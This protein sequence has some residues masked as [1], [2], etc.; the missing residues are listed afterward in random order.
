[1]TTRIVAEGTRF[2][3]QIDWIMAVLVLGAA[4]ASFLYPVLYLKM[5]F[6]LDFNS[7]DFNPAVLV[8][9]FLGVFGLKYLFAAVL[10]T[11][12]GRRFGQAV[13]E[14]DGETVAQGETLKGAVRVPADLVPL[15]DYE[16]HLQC[17]HQQYTANGRLRDEIRWEETLRVNA[18]SANRGGGV[19]FAFMI[20]RD[21]M[22]TAQSTL[23]TGQSVRWI[24]EVKAPLKGLNFYAIFG[25]VVRARPSV[26]SASPS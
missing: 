1:M 20:P 12:R 22:S 10:A 16:F 4:A 26:T 3:A 5:R 6:V 23:M 2:H 24:L 21:A 9:V 17:V 18:Q 7:P 15:G 25:V 8:P 14:M 11:M 19:P 13:M